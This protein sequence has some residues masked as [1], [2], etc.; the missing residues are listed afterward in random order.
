MQK[1]GLPLAR[2][3]LFQLTVFAA[4]SAGLLNYNYEHILKGVR[5]VLKGAKLIAAIS[6]LTYPSK[7]GIIPAYRATISP[8]EMATEQTAYF[9]GKPN[10]LMM[11]TRLRRLGV[12]SKEAVMILVGNI[13]D[14]AAA[15]AAGAATLGL[16]SDST[17]IVFGVII[18]CLA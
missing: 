7:E 16:C 1:N 6:D 13:S 14:S 3:A 4:C 18:Y 8:I 17:G 9:V 2:R 10:L 12:H 5:L 15:A 11:R